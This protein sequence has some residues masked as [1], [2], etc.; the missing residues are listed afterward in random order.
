MSIHNNANSGIKG[1]TVSGF[2]LTDS[3]IANNTN[4]TGEQAGIL[5]NDLTDSAALVTRV[6]VSGSTEDNVRV[7]NSSTPAPSF[8]TTA[9]SRTTALPRAT[10][11]SSSRRITAPN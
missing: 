6:S 9:R 2:K 3:A 11:A 7:H 5:L 8:S 1:T 10:T 4:S